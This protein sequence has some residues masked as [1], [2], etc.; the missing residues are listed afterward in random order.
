LSC[1]ICQTRKEKRFCPALHERICAQCCGT[2]R[3]VSIDCMPDCAY[4][5]QARQHEK[6]RTIEEL[7]GEEL[8]REITLDHRYF[9]DHEP[10]ITGLLYGVAKLIAL[11]KDW[12]DADVT[13]ALTEITRSVA[14]R[15]N[16]GLIL[17]DSTPNP[18]QQHLREELEKMIVQYRQLE[19]QHLGYAKLK[20]SDVMR[21]MVFLVRMA[22]S[23]TNGRRKSRAFL[24][25]L[26]AQFPVQQAGTVAG[27]A[28]ASS[29]IIP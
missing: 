19:E 25:S 23:R 16:S 27:S 6:P 14:T 29:L 20:G 2:E 22:H 15:A 24:D 7:Q 26:R 13:H 8:F 10:L 4:L 1:S 12:T 3:E 11:H 28:N 5:L 17:Q 18:V 21:A 9:Y